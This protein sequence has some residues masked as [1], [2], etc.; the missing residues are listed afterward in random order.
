MCFKCR[1]I[2][3]VRWLAADMRLRCYDGRWAGF[4]RYGLVM[5]VLY[6]VG[7]PATVLWIL[8]RRR[9]KL[10]GSPTDRFVASTRATFGFL[11]AD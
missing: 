3:G 7:L 1:N 4:A 5:A 10:F 6:V 11:Y 8:W 9:H 2:E